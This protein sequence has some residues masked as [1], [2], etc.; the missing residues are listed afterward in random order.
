MY[1]IE[2]NGKIYFYDGERELS[3]K[4]G[5]DHLE[6]IYPYEPAET[7]R[8]IDELKSRYMKDLLR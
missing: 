5:F 2:D 1:A 4:E 8:I 3:L 7:K 6:C